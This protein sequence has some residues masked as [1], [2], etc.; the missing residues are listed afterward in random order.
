MFQEL[1]ARIRDEEKGEGFMEYGL[2]IALIA[3]L[4]IGILLTV[5]S[6]A[7]NIYGNISNSPKNSGK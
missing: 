3:F 1:I 5:N 6:G 2:I 7:N 4:L